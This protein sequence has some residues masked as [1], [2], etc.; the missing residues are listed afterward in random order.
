GSMLYTS[1]RQYGIRIARSST[2][3]FLRIA[4]LDTLLG[5]L[6]TTFA[7]YF[8]RKCEFEHYQH[9]TKVADVAVVPTSMDQSEE[10]IHTTDSG[11]VPETQA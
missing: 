6:S 11:K 7:S 1:M 2:S 5:S 4:Q 8:V 9:V 10:A 3:M